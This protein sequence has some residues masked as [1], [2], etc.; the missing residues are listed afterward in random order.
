MAV[1]T[2][3]PKRKTSAI[4][5]TATGSSTD[6][7]A[8]NLPF[9]IYATNGSLYDSDFVSGA[10]N[11]VAYTYRKL[12]GDVLDIE[13]TT[14]NV[15]AAYEESVFEY[16]YIVNTH[17]AK[18]ML[19]NVLG[20]LTGTFDHQGEFKT[21]SAISSSLGNDRVNL[22]YP[23]FIMGQ[24]ARVGAGV[25][26]EANL[27]GHSSIYS[28]SFVTS[29]SKQDYDLQDI[30]YSASANNTSVPFYN[31]VGKNR[32][33]I[34]KVYYKTPH[35]MWR[36][37]GYYGGL[38]TVGNLHSYGQFADDSSFELVPTWQN[39]LQAMNFEDSIYT[40]TSH[41]SYE[42]KNNKLRIFPQATVA[43]PDKMWVEFTVDENAWTEDH[44]RKHGASGV[45]SMNT[46]PFS[47]IPFK[48]INSIGKQWIRRY[49]I[50]LTKEML[51]QVRGKFGSI[52]I[53]GEA[54]TLNAG[55]LMSQAKEE[56]SSLREE[57]KTVLDELTYARLTEQ[58]ST[59]MDN[60]NR[61]QANIPVPIFTG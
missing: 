15:Y 13:I 49:A 38:N 8:A 58:E 53:P 30:I 25:A 20:D 41:F 50:A 35:A 22:K 29:A 43:H 4:V 14:Q 55:E 24:T 57:L 48:N 37:Y 9:G 45:N 60:V 12:G 32:V 2:L 36:F 51:A 42:V 6:V 19:S 5:L 56:Q 11:Q 39:K 7:T 46:L 61:V 1:P 27:G 34:K 16:S 31:K 18:N 33:T 52:P 47:N 54:V 3:I 40:R 23:K 28:A 44:D 17:Q 26:T 21:T 59:M 10:V